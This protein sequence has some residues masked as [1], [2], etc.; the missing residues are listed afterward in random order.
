MSGSYR[1]VVQPSSFCRFGDV[2]VLPPGI[3][4]EPPIGTVSRR[5]GVTIVTTM[6]FVRGFNNIGGVRIDAEG[7]LSNVAVDQ[8]KRLNQIRQLAL[9]PI[10][11]DFETYTET[12]FRVALL[13]WQRW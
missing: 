6:R 4:I 12:A 13:D 2:S 7:V 8:T 3:A 1:E 10:P 11:G 9:D 5:F